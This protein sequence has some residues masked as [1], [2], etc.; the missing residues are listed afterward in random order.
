[1]RRMHVKGIP[2]H[3]LTPESGVCKGNLLYHGDLIECPLPGSLQRPFMIPCSPGLAPR[4]GLAGAKMWTLLCTW[5][6][7]CHRQATQVCYYF[8]DGDRVSAGIYC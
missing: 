7:S 6:D 1:M 8:L 2:K 5:W 3:E 4:R